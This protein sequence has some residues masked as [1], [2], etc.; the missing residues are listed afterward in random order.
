MYNPD[1]E[2]DIRA[3]DK[4]YKEKLLGDG[5]DT[6]ND[7]EDE[8]LQLVLEMDNDEYLRQ[9]ENLSIEESICESIKSYDKQIEMNKQIEINNRIDS[10]KNFTNKIKLLR[11][12]E[13]DIILQ[14]Y[15]NSVLEQYFKLKIDYVKMEDNDIY[16]ELYK[17]IDSYYLEPFKNNYKKFAIPSEE[18]SILRKIFLCNN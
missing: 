5:S 18:D 14:K 1:E 4:L 7:S 10:L 12:T 3:S 2:S 11:Y 13:K 17:L 15:I 9:I 16:N 6:E 8:E